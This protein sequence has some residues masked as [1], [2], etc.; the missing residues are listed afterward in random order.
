MTGGD[1]GQKEIGRER[2]ITSERKLL[3]KLAE[4]DVGDIYLEEPL[5]KYSKWQIGGPADLLVTPR[6]IQQL[7]RLR[8]HINDNKITSVVV[9]R[10]SNLLF[11][12]AGFRGVVI[13]VGRLLSAFEINGKTVRAEAGVAVPRLARAVGLAGLS[14]IEH[15]IG[16]PGTLGGLIV[17]NGGSRRESIGEVVKI[18][19]A[20][21]SNGEIHEMSREQCDFSYRH[22]IFQKSDRLVVR[23]ELELE[24]GRAAAI[25]KE[26]LEV[27]RERRKKFPRHL[28]NCGSV[29]ASSDR[30]YE[31]FGPPGKVIEDAGLKG[32]RLGGAQVSRSHANFIVNTGNATSRDVL[33][34]IRQVRTV[35]HDKTGI[36]MKCEVKFVGTDGQIGQLSQRKDIKQ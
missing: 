33:E 2:P 9:G 32:L 16:I 20:M 12:D 36:W 21:D 10:G 23:V 18:V 5:R 11:D 31:R 35:V 15:T 34:L 19:E 1:S 3:E 22:S 14:G 25:R 6:N 13:V 8:R 4:L 30:L 17:M 27:L 26:M 29:F 7:C 28:P 24:Y